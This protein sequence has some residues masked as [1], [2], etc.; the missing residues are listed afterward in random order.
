LTSAGVHLNERENYLPQLW[1]DPPGKVKEVYRRL[2][3]RPSFTLTRIF[4]DYKQGIDNDLTPKFK[5]I[6]EL[7]G[8]YEQKANKAIAD[9]EFY[10]L[11]RENG[12]IRPQGKGEED[13]KIL[14]PNHF[15]AAYTVNRAGQASSVPM[16]APPE[17]HELISNYLDDPNK[18]IQWMADKASMSKNIAMSSGVPG[19]AINAH[20]FNILAR[21]VIGNPKAALTAGKYILNPR[22]AGRALDEAL[23][24]APWAVKQGLQLTTEGHE[25]GVSGSTNL[26]GQTFQKFL[27]VQ[28]K[29]FEDPLFQNVIPALKLKHFNDMVGDLVKNGMSREAA[30]KS[31]A[32]MTNNLYGGI[33]WEAM[34]RSRDLQNLA[35]MVVLAPDWLESNIKLGNGMAKTLLDP[36]NPQGK[37]YAKMAR[38]IIGAYMAADVSNYA[39]SGHHMW[40]NPAGHALDI[41]AGKSNGKDRWIRPFGTAADFLRLPY[42]AASAALAKNP[43]FGT[44]MD[45]AKNR[46]SIPA[47]VG[48]D[49]ITKRDRSNRPILGKDDY[50]RPI[51]PGKQIAG[52]AGELSSGASSLC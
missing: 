32:E 37:F 35:R 16:T 17:L 47:R 14:D 26:A 46:M 41:Q 13:W 29:L 18:I 43:D 9:R 28:G 50:G 49:L 10:N 20:G 40:E 30:G 7:A 52:T 42:D 21:T 4:E 24:T 33:N 38:N 2:G 1:E 45:I 48:L 36:K 8:W 12:W 5:N 39:M 23:H 27:K 34:G 15:P 25:M 19:T 31:A 11:G 22:S 51:P 44:P 3:L 6:G